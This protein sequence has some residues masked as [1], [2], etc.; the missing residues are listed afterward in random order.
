MKKK[1]KILAMIALTI[2]CFVA[3]D[4]KREKD[5][6]PEYVSKSNE[7]KK[8]DEGIYKEYKT[9]FDLKHSIDEVANEL[10]LVFESAR[11]KEL[12]D[13]AAI[14]EAKDHDVKAFFCTSSGDYIEIA[15]IKLKDTDDLMWALETAGKRVDVLKQE[16]KILDDE[17]GVCI[18]VNNGVLT[19][20]ASPKGELD[21]S[22]SITKI[23]K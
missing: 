8:S 7:T 13:A 18:E 9:D 22:D 4:F 11:L 3:C 15:S 19:L 5:S 6:V 23:L 1:L 16:N 2:C 14:Y 21:I 20:V 10:N 12:K 17:N